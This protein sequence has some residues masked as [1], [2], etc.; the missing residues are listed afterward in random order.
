MYKQTTKSIC[1]PAL[2]NTDNMHVP[3]S[4]EE[5]QVPSHRVPDTIAKTPVVE[6]WAPLRLS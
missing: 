3:Q 6:D 2:D 1:F 5:S 4:R